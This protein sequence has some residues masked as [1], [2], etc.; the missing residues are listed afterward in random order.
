VIV[1][2][3]GDLVSRQTVERVGI[4]DLGSNTTRLIVMEHTPQHSFKLTDEVS[5]V[6][7]LAEGVGEDGAL[8]PEPMYR[9][10]EAL[11]MFHTFCQ[12][13]GVNHVVAVGTSAV[14]EASNQAE[15]LEMLK[16]ETGL[17]LRILS[18]EEE[19]YYGYLGVVNSLPI[20]DGYV[21]DIGGGSTEVTEIYGRQFSRSFSQPTGIVRLTERFVHSDPISKSDFRLLEQ[22]ATEAFAELDWLKPTPGTTLVGIGG[23]IRN[24]ARIDQK[25]RRYP[26]GRIHGY[27]LQR[28]S[29]ET[30]I[31]SLRRKSQPEREDVPGLNRD[32]ADVIVAGAVILHQLMVQGGFDELTVGGEGLREGLFYEHFLAKQERPVLDDVRSFSINNLARVYHYEATHA[33]KVQEIS[34]SLFDQ[35]RD[36]H[37]YGAWERELLSYA[38]TLHDIGVQVGYY[39]H[40]KHSAYLVL[41]SSLQGFSHREVAL[42]A[43]LVRVHRKGSVDPREFRMVLED[44]DVVRVSRLGSLLRIAEYLERSK[45]QV[46]EQLNVGVGENG[47]TIEVKP[48]GDATVEIWA[49]NRRANLFRETFGCDVQIV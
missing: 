31:S 3:G 47:V 48:K 44:D 37:H 41:N 35:L 46:V 39:D 15:F 49:A 20:S 8:Q 27:V 32:R 16:R 21:I 28:K 6:V 9:A 5:E 7:R 29:L 24:L 17:E 22:G 45:S 40:H 1:N 26:L 19:A 33:A 14:R 42:L 4:I 12:A 11:K 25:R 23:T 18:G 10:V 2:I 38:A 34:L 30:I 43:M 13:S 36:L